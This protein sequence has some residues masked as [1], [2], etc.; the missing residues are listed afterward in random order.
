MKASCTVGV[1]RAGEGLVLG[2]DSDLTSNDDEHP[3]EGKSASEWNHVL[4]TSV[5]SALRIPELYSQ[6]AILRHRRLGL[7]G[8]AER[9]PEGPSVRESDFGAAVH[10]DNP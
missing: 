6:R 5:G 10:G 4:G 1:G 3:E 7:G 2:S 9:G 8:A